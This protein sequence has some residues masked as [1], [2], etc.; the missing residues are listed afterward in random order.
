LAPEFKTRRQNIPVTTPARTIADLRRVAPPEVVRRAVRQAV[1]VGLDI[2]EDVEADFTRSELERRFLH[3]CRR[4]RL[5]SPQVN[6]RVGVFRVDFLWPKQRLIVETDGYRY[7]SGRQAFEDDRARDVELR[8][9]GY[10]VVRFTHRQLTHDPAG[11]AAALRAVLRSESRASG[12][13]RRNTS[14]E[15]G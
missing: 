8:L 7:H 12:Q 15:G 6:S 11:V 9:L 13:T 4:H 2:P 14:H 1:V 5:P 10:D 3:L